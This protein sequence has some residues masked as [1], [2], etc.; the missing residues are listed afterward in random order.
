M[1]FW[2][3]FVIVLSDA[4]RHLSHPVLNASRLSRRSSDCKV[5]ALITEYDAVD[6]AEQSHDYTAT[7]ANDQCISRVRRI[8]NDVQQVGCVGDVLR[9]V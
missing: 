8:L 6:D 1:H 5:A 2:R 3:I 4:T 9:L 7:T